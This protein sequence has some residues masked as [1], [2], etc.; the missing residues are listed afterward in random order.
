MKI[1]YLG[2]GAAEGWP[3]VF[4]QCEPCKQ[5]RRLGGKNIRHRSSS[6]INDSLLIDFSAD[7]YSQSLTHSVDLSVVKNIL[8]THNHEDHFYAHELTNIADPFGHVLDGI[9]VK[10]YGSST[11]IENATQKTANS[12][13]DG[14][15]ELIEVKAYQPFA[16]GDVTVTPLTANHG[17]GVSFI[18]LLQSGGKTML[19]AHDTGWLLDDVWR[20]LQGKRLDYVSMDGTCIDAQRYTSHM[21]LDENI[22][23]KERLIAMCCADSRTVFVSNHFSHNGLL[24]HEQIEARLLPHGILTS[25]DGMEVEF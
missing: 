4:C 14:C 21:T 17:A 13:M 23:M 12:E 15:L 6:F 19:Y 10:L 1:K 2:T 7:T 3:A 9:P 11:V 5:A 18:Y 24:L 8:V 16:A 25:Y 22:A 20:F